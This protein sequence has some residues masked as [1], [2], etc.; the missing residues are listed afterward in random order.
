MPTQRMET[1]ADLAGSAVGLIAAALARPVETWAASVTIGREVLAS[2]TDGAASAAVKGDK[3]FRD[4][5]WSSNPAG[6]VIANRLPRD[7]LELVPRGHLFI[8]T[9]PAGTAARIEEFIHDRARP[10]PRAPSPHSPRH[11]Q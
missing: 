8:L 11:S 10:A 2:L 6:R 3:R 4:P 1:A 5:V 7:R 9:D